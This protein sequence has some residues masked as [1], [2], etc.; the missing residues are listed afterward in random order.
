MREGG[1]DNSNKIFSRLEPGKDTTRETSQMYVVMRLLP[2]ITMI[3][4]AI[5][6]MSF[7]RKIRATI[8]QICPSGK[9]SAIGGK[10]KR[11]IITLGNSRIIRWENNHIFP[12]EKFAWTWSSWSG[13]LLIH[14]LCCLY[15]HTRTKWVNLARADM[16][17][18]YHKLKL[19]YI[20]LIPYFL[21]FIIFQPIEGPIFLEPVVSVTITLI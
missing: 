20:A 7:T 12:M 4:W 8:R 15:S 5:G 18:A 2:L 11:N 17:Q 14:S 13:S 1:G 6:S 9:L 21:K 3:I 10:W 19:D 16:G